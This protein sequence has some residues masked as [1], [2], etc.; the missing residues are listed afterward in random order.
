MIKEFQSNDKGRKKVSN[1]KE[2]MN[3]VIEL[4]SQN[5][6]DERLKALFITKMEEAI[7]FGTKAILSKQGHNNGEVSY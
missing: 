6:G 3:A 5:M 7:M 4:H 1:M 2:S